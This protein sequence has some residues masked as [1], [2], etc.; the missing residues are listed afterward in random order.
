MNELSVD[1]CHSANDSIRGV[2][3]VVYVWRRTR[4]IY[5]QSSRLG[6]CHFEPMTVSVL[7]GRNSLPD[8]HH[9]SWNKLSCDSFLANFA[10]D[11]VRSLL[12]LNHTE[13]ESMGQIVGPHPV[14]FGPYY[15]HRDPWN[16]STLIFFGL[17]MYISHQSDNLWEYHIVES[18]LEDHRRKHGR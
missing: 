11:D 17:C 13:G 12:C 4:N 9:S 5:S 16:S 6:R 14:P 3:P 2:Y 1:I 15:F 18:S 7:R 10:Q 8:N